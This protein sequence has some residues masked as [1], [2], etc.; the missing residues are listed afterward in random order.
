MASIDKTLAKLTSR[1]A[2]HKEIEAVLLAGSRATEFSD[3]DS[4]IDLYIYGETI[5]PL[6][7]RKT[8]LRDFSDHMEYNN[9]YWETEDDGYL[10]DPYIAIDILYRDLNWIRGEMERVVF[11]HQAGTGYSTCIWFNLLNSKILF[12]RNGKLTALQKKVNIAYPQRLKQNII[13]KNYPLLRNSVCSYYNQIKK[14]LGRDDFISVNHRIAAFFES[15]FDIIFAINEMP[16]PGEK[17]LVRIVQSQCSLKPKNFEANIRN[18]FSKLSPPDIILLSSL[19][20][21]IENLDM[22]LTNKNV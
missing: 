15:Y 4:D 10:R 14:A 20:E 21:L 1:F 7:K 22:L 19:D 18:V 3:K 5:L 17:K 6:E 13:K 16:H 11:Q 8:I 9:Q 2:E 12:D